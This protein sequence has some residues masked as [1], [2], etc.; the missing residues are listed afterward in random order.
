[1]Y[2]FFNSYFVIPFTY[3]YSRFGI[4]SKVQKIRMIFD[5][6]PHTHPSKHIR[7]LF[8]ITK[9]TTKRK[10]L[11][12]MLKQHVERALVLKTK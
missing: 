9:I 8:Q 11:Y 7:N 5:T 4:P 1:M 2:V 10:T 3:M 6:L 12:M